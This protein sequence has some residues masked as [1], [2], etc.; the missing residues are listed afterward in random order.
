M[1][2][3]YQE[4]DVDSELTVYLNGEEIW[5][6]DLVHDSPE[7]CAWIR[8]VGRINDSVTW[9]MQQHCS[10][11]LF[12]L[13][14][15][16]E[17][18]GKKALIRKCMNLTWNQHCFDGVTTHH[19][20]A[21]MYWMEMRRSLD[22]PDYSKG[23]SR[24]FTVLERIF[25]GVNIRCPDYETYARPLMAV[26]NAQAD[27]ESSAA[28]DDSDSSSDMDVER[29]PVHDKHLYFNRYAYLYERH[30]LCL[31]NID[32]LFWQGEVPGQEEKKPWLVKVRPEGFLELCPLGTAEKPLE[33]VR[34]P[35]EF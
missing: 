16:E 1:V 6:D 11:H 7:D 29:T 12:M 19:S 8:K 26:A 25:D 20:Q 34:R 3:T 32:D 4:G 28:E 14:T 30:Y 23:V 10:M 27:E 15:R 13:M 21:F 9:R 31:G 5:D 35:D 17:D 22:H 33:E 2:S 18:R 24:V